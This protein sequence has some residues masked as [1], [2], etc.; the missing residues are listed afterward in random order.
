M[1]KTHKLNINKLSA[2]CIKCKFKSKLDRK[3]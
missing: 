2:D 1:F 3:V